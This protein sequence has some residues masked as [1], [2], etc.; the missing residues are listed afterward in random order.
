MGGTDVVAGRE[1]RAGEGPVEAEWV[2]T[3]VCVLE[4]GW[5]GLGRGGEEVYIWGRAP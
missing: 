2:V 4:V 1:E 3:Y 5:M